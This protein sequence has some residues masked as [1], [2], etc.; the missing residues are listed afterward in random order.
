MWEIGRDASGDDRRAPVPCTLRGAAPVHHRAVTSRALL[1][2]CAQILKQHP[3]QKEDTQIMHTK[4][5]DHS[6]LSI[7]GT[8]NTADAS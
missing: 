6:N 7:L 2:I 4:L 3:R 8:A 5:G 1:Q